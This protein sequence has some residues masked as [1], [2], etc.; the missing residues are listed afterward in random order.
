M[1]MSDIASIPANLA[2]LPGISLPCGV[3]DGLPIGLQMLGEPL[4][5]GT[6][7]RAAHGL[8]SLLN[9]EIDSLFLKAKIKSS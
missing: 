5:D 9:L 7:L 6:L 2:G 8:E 3:A 4:S 1:Y